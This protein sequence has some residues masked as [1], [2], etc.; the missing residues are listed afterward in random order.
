MPVLVTGAEA[1]LG[2]LTA[3]ALLGAGGEVRVYLDSEVVGD[4]EAAAFRA[5]GCKTAIGEID[6][7]GRL[8]A[9][10]EQVHTVVHCWGGPLTP[11]EEELDG[12]AGVLS[13]ALGAGCRRIIWPSHLGADGPGDV[14]YLQAC[15]DAEELLADST[16]ESIVVRR[17]LTYGPD[18]EL[19]RRL[20]ADGGRSV[21]QDALQAPLLADD[22]ANLIVRADLA[23]RDVLRTDLAL[24]LELAGPEVMPFARLVRALQRSGV[25]RGAAADSLPPSTVAL[26]G[27][28]QE[29]GPATLGREGTPLA[30]GL[31]TLQPVR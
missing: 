14:A 26:Y 28:D 7:E 9:A 19:T 3:R 24:V 27:R 4:D 10:L 23:N 31:V 12:V 5:M 8:E 2:R 30:S 11:P 29:P 21:R 15:A 25:G 1:G 17:A 16:L 18:D 22:L 6:D 13:A 20:A